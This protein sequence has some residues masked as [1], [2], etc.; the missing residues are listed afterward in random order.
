[1]K[2]FTIPTTAHDHLDNPAAILIYG[3]VHSILYPNEIDSVV[4][5]SKTLAEV[6]CCTSDRA[7]AI[8]RQLVKQGL[9]VTSP[10]REYDNK[11]NRFKRTKRYYLPTRV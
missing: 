8:V 7:N 9:L 2:R 1:M 6:G 4:I 5:N 3:Y 11:A 10:E